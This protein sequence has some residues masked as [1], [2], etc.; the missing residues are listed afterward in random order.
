M[1]AHFGFAGYLIAVDQFVHPV[2]LLA[3][4]NWHTATLDLKQLIMYID[5]RHNT[6]ISLN[7]SGRVK[8]PKRVDIVL[9]GRLTA[10]RLDEGAWEC[11]GSTRLQVHL[12]DQVLRQLCPSFEPS[13][14]HCKAP[15]SVLV[16]RTNHSVAR[17][18]LPDL[19]KAFTLGRNSTHLS[20]F[21]YNQLK[22][23]ETLSVV[24]RSDS[25]SV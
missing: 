25:V 22:G 21:Y 1:G 10:V 8:A 15:N 2:R 17:C 11:A 7:V 4:G 9:N 20:F 14:C 19:R 3:D 24:F 5:G 16:P 6:A 18:Q 13:Y 23:R 12:T